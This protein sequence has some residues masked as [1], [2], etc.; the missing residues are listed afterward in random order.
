MFDKISLSV[1]HKGALQMR[2]PA[3]PNNDNVQELSSFLNYAESGFYPSSR[4][5]DGAA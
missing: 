1:G 4:V 3:N 5:A 2:I